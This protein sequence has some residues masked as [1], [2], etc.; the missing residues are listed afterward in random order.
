M[1]ECE[2]IE[3]L[4]K[5]LADKSRLQILDCIQNGVSNPGEIAKE[6]DRHR[7]TIEKHLR[8]LL[9]ANIVEKV[10]SLT[11]SGHLSVYYRIRDNANRLLTTI[12]EACQKA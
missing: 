8:V 9:K 1:S 11:K 4:L 5:A 7:S 12:Q 3:K 2:K 10:P 6:L